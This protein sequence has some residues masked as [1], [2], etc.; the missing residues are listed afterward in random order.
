[1]EYTDSFGMTSRMWGETCGF[2]RK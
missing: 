1:M 2:L